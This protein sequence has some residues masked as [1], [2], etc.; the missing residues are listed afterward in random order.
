MIKE[1]KPPLAIHFIWNP[2]D[3]GFV[4]TILDAVMSSFARDVDR[5][6][7]RGLN[8]PLFFYTSCIIFYPFFDFRVLKD[9]PDFF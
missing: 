5:P 2:A 1:Y 7:S 6:F 3:E 4:S 8:I 9:P